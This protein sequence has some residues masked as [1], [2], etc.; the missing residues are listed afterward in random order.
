[1]QKL[2][3]ALR[4]S[5]EDLIKKVKIDYEDHFVTVTASSKK[6]EEIL[7]V[8]I[9]INELAVESFKRQLTIDYLDKVRHTI[10]TWKRPKPQKFKVGDVFTIPLSDD[11]FAFGQ[12]LWGSSLAPNCGLFDFKSKEVVSLDMVM[13]ARCI[14]VLQIGS[15]CLKSFEWLVIG[16]AP[17]HINK[18]QVPKVHRGECVVGAE[19]YSPGIL[20]DLAESFYGVAQWQ[21][22]FNRLLMPG[23]IPKNTSKL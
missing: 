23:I 14:S 20:K 9:Q 10:L 5:E 16:N 1:M 8:A 3:R 18:E 22:F 13:A 21:G 2:R 15:H 7:K 4:N 11:S 6:G 19:S 17:V 12:V